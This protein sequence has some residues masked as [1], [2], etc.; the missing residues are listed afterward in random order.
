M[1]GSQDLAGEWETNIANVVTMTALF[2]PIYNFNLTSFSIYYISLYRG[3]LRIEA[4]VNC[5]K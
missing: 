3:L 2:I 1:A 4:G 5:Y